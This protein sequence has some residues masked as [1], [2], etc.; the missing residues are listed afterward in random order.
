MSECVALTRI[1]V[2]RKAR[3]YPVIFDMV[4]RG[5]IHLTALRVLSPHLTQQNLRIG[6]GPGSRLFKTRGG[7][8]R[9]TAQAET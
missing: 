3:D 5:E 6:S 1:Q 2:M 9:R 4:E 7:T 8:D